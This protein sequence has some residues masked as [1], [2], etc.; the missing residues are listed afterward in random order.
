MKRRAFTI[1]A[2]TTLIFNA[3]P[4]VA[5]D[6]KTV[7]LEIT[8]AF[9]RASPKMVSAGAGF[10]TIRSLGDSDRLIGFSSPACTQPE[11]HTHVHDNGMMRMRQ[12]DAVD[13]PAGGVTKLEPGG[14]HLMFIGLTGK[15]VEGETVDV[16]L[17]FEKAGMVSITLPI[18]KSG[19]MN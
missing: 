12:V 1:I 5:Q 19:A 10:M 18:K 16:T 9:A 2:V 8:G 7:N 3:I 17:T 13:I 15:L 4:T 6:A 11:L 14:F